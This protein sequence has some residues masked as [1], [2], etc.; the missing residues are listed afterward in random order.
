MRETAV[1]ATTTC[2]GCRKTIKGKVIMIVP[3]RLHVALGVPYKNYHPSC[4]RRN[5]ITEWE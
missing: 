2:D 3:S 4:A 1:A 5:G